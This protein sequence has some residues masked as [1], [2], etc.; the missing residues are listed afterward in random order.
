MKIPES[1]T[2]ITGEQKEGH[3]KIDRFFNRILKREIKVPINHPWVERKVKIMWGSNDP[4][5]SPFSQPLPQ[6]AYS[7]EYIHLLLYKQNVIAAVFETRNS[8]NY[9]HFDFFCNQENLEKLIQE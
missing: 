4:F 8:N 9:V 5:F 6:G 1:A 3:K 7:D 2:Y